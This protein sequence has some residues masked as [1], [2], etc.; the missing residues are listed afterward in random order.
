MNKGKAYAWYSVIA[1][2]NTDEV[3]QKA[4][5]KR[6]LLEKKLNKKELAAYQQALA[7]WKFSTPERSVSK[8][9]KANMKIPVIY[10]LNDAKSLQDALVEFG[11]LP[12]N[13]QRYDLTTS[14]IDQAI[15]L[16]SLDALTPKIEKAQK[17]GKKDAYGY[18]GDLFKSRF[19]NPMEAFV[20]YKKGAEEGDEYARYQM[21]KMLCEGM[22][23][24]PDIA[25]CYAGMIQV[26]EAQHP[27]L[28]MLAQNALATILSQADEKKLQE[29]LKPT[30]KKEK[31]KSSE[32]NGAFDFF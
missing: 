26:Q 1:A 14:L 29:A 27:V 31:K 11:F 32:S 2:Y 25:Q 20:W 7:K 23:V 21:S 28:N 9:E 24:E 19:N 3:G 16:E 8:E 22:G 17:D 15:G 4:Q 12:R 10:G 13:P 30:D 18:Y 5:E 6:D